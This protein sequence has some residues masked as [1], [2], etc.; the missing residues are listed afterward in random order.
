MK[1]EKEKKGGGRGGEQREGE[2]DPLIIYS[3]SKDEEN[4]I[5]CAE[6]NP[7]ETLLT[8]SLTPNRFSENSQVCVS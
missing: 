6:R 7:F 1:E 3:F 2:R 8:A 4:K 5:L